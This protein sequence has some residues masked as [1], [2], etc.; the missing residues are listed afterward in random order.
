MQEGEKHLR[1][2]KKVL[3]VWRIF[4]ICIVKAKRSLRGS[5]KKRTNTAG[6]QKTTA[7]SLKTDPTE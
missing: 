2:F 6:G 1:F 7:L 4:D 3:D 5:L